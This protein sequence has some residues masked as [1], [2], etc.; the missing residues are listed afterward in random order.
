MKY[1]ILLFTF[2]FLL[3]GCVLVKDAIFPPKD[4]G[5]PDVFKGIKPKIF[6]FPLTVASNVDGNWENTTYYSGKEISYWIYL[7]IKDNCNI[8]FPDTSRFF[9]SDTKRPEYVAMLEFQESLAASMLKNSDSV[10]YWVTKSYNNTSMDSSTYFYLPLCIEKENNHA[11][12]GSF[13]IIIAN[14]RGEI[15]YARMI[16]YNPITWS[17]NYKNFR[18][19][20][21]NKMPL[22]KWGL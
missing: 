19:D 1:K 10:Q 4:Y 16:D 8:L 15:L 17:E 21:R 5:N 22:A 3:S 12:S 14:N 6:L 13:F 20:T 18:D 11:V 9:K 7:R 2:A